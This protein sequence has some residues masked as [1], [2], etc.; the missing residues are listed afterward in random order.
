MQ[1]HL[2]IIPLSKI[3]IFLSVIPKPCRIQGAASHCHFTPFGQPAGGEQAS[4]KQ[5]ELNRCRKGSF[6]HIHL[7]FICSAHDDIA[8]LWICIH[9][10]FVC[11]RDYNVP[12]DGEMEMEMVMV[13]VGSGAEAGATSQRV[14]LFLHECRS[15][16]LKLCARWGPKA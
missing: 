8:A 14:A 6:I 15:S 16:P 2:H 4:S 7:L 12:R 5:T 1:T 9:Y 11:A 3:I 13:M 10:L